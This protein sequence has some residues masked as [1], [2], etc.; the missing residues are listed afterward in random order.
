MWRKFFCWIC[1]LII[2]KW[3]QTWGQNLLGKVCNSEKKP[4]E[5]VN[6]VIYHKDKVFQFTQTN[7]D[8][9]FIFEKIPCDSILLQFSLLDYKTEKLLLATPC[10]NQDTLHITLIEENSFIEEI[11]VRGKNDVFITK[12]TTEFNVSHY[13]D[14]TER[15]MEDLLR[16]L[17][18]IEINEKGKISFFNK[19]I[20]KITLDGDDL[21]GRN[22]ELL[23]RTMPT[24]IT[25]KVQVIERFNENKLLKNINLSQGVILNFQVKKE[26]KNSLFGRADL[27]IGT[28]QRADLNAN[29]TTLSPK[30]KFLGKVGYNNIGRMSAY[31]EEIAQEKNQTNIFNPADA[32][33]LLENNLEP[34][35][36]HRLLGAVPIASQVSV[37]NNEKTAS[38]HFVAKPNK[39]TQIQSGLLWG[40]DDNLFTNA[41]VTQYFNLSEPFRF[42]ALDRMQNQPHLYGGKLK[43]YTDLNNTTNLLV[44]S[45]LLLRKNWQSYLSEANVNVFHSG[46]QANFSKIEHEIMLT[47]KIDTSLAI[48]SKISFH[49]RMNQE[50]LQLEA[51]KPLT[52]PTGDVSEKPILQNL[53]A[54]VQFIQLKN[55][56]YGKTKKIN[57]SVGIS[58]DIKYNR[59]NTSLTHIIPDSTVQGQSVFQEKYAYAFSNFLFLTKKWRISHS[60]EIGIFN[61]DLANYQS[62]IFQQKT[63][64]TKT[65]SWGTGEG[66]YQYTWNLPEFTT[67]NTMGFYTNY[68]IFEQGS[69]TYQPSQIHEWKA[70][71]LLHKPYGLPYATFSVSYRIRQQ[72]YF[73]S[74]QANENL[75]L[76]KWELN[77]G[78]NFQN[79]NVAGRFSHFISNLLLNVHLEPSYGYQTFQSV[80]EDKVL[81]NK[82]SIYKLKLGIGSGFAG[83][84]NFRN[85]W[86]ATQNV[87]NTQTFSTLQGHLSLQYKIDS[88]FF[89]RFK[90]DIWGIWQNKQQNFN[91]FGN[92]EIKKTWRKL[93]LELLCHNL[94]NAQSYQEQWNTEFFVSSNKI[95]LLPRYLMVKLGINF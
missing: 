21:T 93:D 89:I 20:E 63:S 65:F 68:R 92:L 14:G 80:V 15:N 51:E 4:L 84:F 25:E 67:W 90:N 61:N 82:A 78:F 79:L 60:N 43:I 38:G 36:Q 41:L 47:K 3:E 26:Y 91:F 50:I 59:W 23:S 8:G 75:L 22:Y 66:S 94:Y 32:F 86:T 76:W 54:Q 56:L 85:E 88:G 69:Q 6:A 48:I 37:L 73:L 95:L 40:K 12:D 39:N 81:A 31:I 9:Y 7:E 87:V 30:F 52:T 74:T 17:P 1:L 11:I 13:A 35:M 49:E 71:L 10:A 53:Q 42:Q 18:G 19:P 27:G 16:K 33:F 46:V 44:Q 28:Y 70:N 72:G 29:I 24:R 58:Q 2:A 83:R 62:T 34:I 57:Y 64:F 5:F 45:N 55:I 77:K